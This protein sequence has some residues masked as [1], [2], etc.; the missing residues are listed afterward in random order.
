MDCGEGIPENWKE[1]TEECLA[2]QIELYDVY[3]EKAEGRIKCWF[4]LRQ[5]L[6]NSDELILRTREEAE[7]RETGC[8]M[9]VSEI[10]FEN[11]FVKNHRMIE[12]KKEKEKREE[13]EKKAPN[14]VHQSDACRGGTVRHLDA[15]SCLYPGLLAAHSLWVDES[16][17]G[18]LA[19]EGVKIA[20]CPAAAMKMLGFC[21]VEKL[22]NAGCT[23]GIGTDGAPSNNRMNLMG[24][25]Q[26][27]LSLP[28]LL[29]LTDKMMDFSHLS[30]SSVMLCRRDVS[31]QSDQQGTAC[32]L[33]REHLTRGSASRDDHRDGA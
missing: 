16:E 27:F 15:L 21:P 17:I 29:H 23:V 12:N 30:L 9:H 18:M 24:K 26:L 22:L 4:G 33:Y 25:S 20:H 19:K 14:S 8:H 7:K 10:T 5:I 11:N 31:H 6:N 1:S 32:N 28:A 3:H 2:K 13:K